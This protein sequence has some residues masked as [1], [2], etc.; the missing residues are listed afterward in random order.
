MAAYLNKAKEQ[1]SSFFAAS[2]K[3]IP[4]S[5]NSSADALAKL[6]LT[7]DADL[8]DAVFVEFLIK[9]SIH[10]QQGVMKLT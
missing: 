9:P 6:A 7:R 2:I 3:V 5:I 1:L 4:R 10:P 8:L